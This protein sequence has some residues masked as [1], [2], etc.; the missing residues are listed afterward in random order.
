MLLYLSFTTNYAEAPFKDWNNISVWISIL[1]LCTSLKTDDNSTN[2]LQKRNS[3]KLIIYSFFATLTTNIQIFEVA[4]FGGAQKQY[5][6]CIIAEVS[7]Y[8]SLHIL[9]WMVG[10]V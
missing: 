5:A 10:I 1:F 2:K 6:R 3:L 8:V 9:S 4:S 7:V